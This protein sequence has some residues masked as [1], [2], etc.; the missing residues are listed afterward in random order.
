[1]VFE[2]IRIVQGVT[3]HH[4]DDNTDHLGAFPMTL[5]VVQV[6]RTVFG[7]FCLSLVVA[8]IPRL[9]ISLCTV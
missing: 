7:C 6:N 4:V 9:F 5:Y 2:S 3:T 8:L 1:M